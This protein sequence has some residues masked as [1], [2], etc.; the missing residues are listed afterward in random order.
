MTQTKRPT[1]LDKLLRIIIKEPGSGWADT[2]LRSKGLP[3][4]MR[5]L[6]NCYPG[7][8]FYHQVVRAASFNTALEHSTAKLKSD[9]KSKGITSPTTIP[10]RDYK[11]WY[12]FVNEKLWPIFHHLEEDNASLDSP[13]VEEWQLYQKVNKK[14]AKALARDILEDLANDRD[15]QFDL[16]WLHDYQLMLVFYYLPSY[17]SAVISEKAPDNTPRY[18]QDKQ[19]ALRQQLPK[20]LSDIQTSYFHHIPWPNSEH[21]KRA[22]P[23]VSVST[24]KTPFNEEDDDSDTELAFEEETRQPSQ[25]FNIGQNIIDG[26]L[27]ANHL[28]FQTPKDVAHFIEC[29]KVYYPDANIT[30]IDEHEHDQRIILHSRTR[31]VCVHPIGTNYELFATADFSTPSAQFEAD[32]KTLKPLTLKSD[33]Q[34]FTSIGR[35]DP[36]KNVPAILDGYFAYI[37]DCIENNQPIQNKLLLFIV[38]SRLNVQAYQDELTAILN[39]YTDIKTYLSQ[40]QQTPA[41]L[42]KLAEETTL[43]QA[44]NPDAHPPA[45]PKLLTPNGMAE[46]YRLGP[47]IISSRADGMNLSIK[48]WV[49][50]QERIIKACLQNLWTFL[51]TP[52]NDLGVCTMNNQESR[53]FD[54]YSAALREEYSNHQDIE[55]RLHTLEG[56]FIE[57]LT[58]FFKQYKQ[59]I[60]ALPML[61]QNAGAAIQLNMAWLIDPLNPETIKKAFQDIP[62][63][64]PIERVAR[65]LAL[66]ANV[67]LENGHRWRDDI[68]KKAQQSSAFNNTNV[69]ARGTL[70]RHSIYQP[71]K[72]QYTPEALEQMSQKHK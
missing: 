50:A 38:P 13:T 11:T 48:E 52:P 6:L 59:D 67:K 19:A 37:K 28:G 18:T 17:L 58:H 3:E 71:K 7:S 33:P 22:F 36:Q 39:K 46:F 21:F 40:H 44:L 51:G 8:S 42:I 70:S 1:N 53:F 12:Q 27:A 41:S 65:A 14:Y 2:V 43:R 57:C 63:L 68:L 56:S 20:I 60:P 62:S 32:Q 30:P 24:D 45:T 29:V 15:I 34:L 25:H 66:R 16:N 26:L 55:R 64:S 35:L 61:S 49:A 47:I 69:P 54:I 31:D 9:L 23:I 10:E 4:G 5:W 72:T